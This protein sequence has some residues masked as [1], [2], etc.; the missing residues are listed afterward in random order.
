MLVGAFVADAA[1]MPFHWVYS[2]ATITRTLAGDVY[3]APLPT[4]HPERRGL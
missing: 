3:P 4:F 1:A 2:S